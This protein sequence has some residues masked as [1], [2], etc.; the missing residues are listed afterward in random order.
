MLSLDQVRLI[1]GYL[2]PVGLGKGFGYSPT[3]L[4]PSAGARN[5]KNPP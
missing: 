5:R 2:C 4:E 1:K 3:W